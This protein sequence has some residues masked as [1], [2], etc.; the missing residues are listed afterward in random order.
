MVIHRSGRD[1]PVAGRVVESAVGSSVGWG[2]GGCCRIGAMGL[3]LVAD[4]SLAR[5][6]AGLVVEMDKAAAAAVVVAAVAEV[7]TAVA[8]V[9]VATVV[10]AAT[11]LLDMVGAADE[12]CPA[13]VVAEG[14]SESLDSNLVQP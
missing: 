11:A 9:V 5:G 7:D 10:V 2:G 8:V 6:T 1:I 14:S 13:A 4:S 3:V 12:P